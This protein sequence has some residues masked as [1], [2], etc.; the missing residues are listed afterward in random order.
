MHSLCASQYLFDGGNSSRFI[1]MKTV[2]CTLRKILPFKRMGVLWPLKQHSRS[3]TPYVVL[4]GFKSH[5]YLE[6]LKEKRLVW[7]ENCLP[8]CTEF[9]GYRS[10]ALC[11]IFIYYKY[12]HTD[13][14]SQ[15]LVE[16]EHYYGTQKKK[17][18]MVRF[19]TVRALRKK[20]HL[21]RRGQRKCR[22]TDPQWTCS[23]KMLP[24]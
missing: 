5:V 2:F 23:H 1:Y 4:K 13:V 8:P 18:S 10:T 6:F 12:T 15:W 11:L 22:T 7:I 14:P 24:I 21:Q 17:H 9:G 16:H 19:N 3:L 20:A